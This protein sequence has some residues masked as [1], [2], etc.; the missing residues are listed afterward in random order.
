MKQ[1][2]LTLVKTQGEC[3]REKWQNR[4]DRFCHIANTGNVPNGPWNGFFIS[5]RQPLT[6]HQS[7]VMTQRVWGVPAI[8]RCGTIPFY[9]PAAVVRAVI[10]CP[11]RNI[12]IRKPHYLFISSLRWIQTPSYIDLWLLMHRQTIP[13]A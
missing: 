11:C 4:S 13:Y 7:H 1:K 3:G 9:I 10:C 5:R 6:P 2:D 8:L 12:T